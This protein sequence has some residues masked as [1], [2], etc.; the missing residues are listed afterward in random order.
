MAGVEGKVLYE[1]E[2]VVS[3]L[4]LSHVAAQ[5]LDIFIPMLYAGTVY[6]AQPN[7]LRVGTP[8]THLILMF[9]ASYLK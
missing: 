3:Y 6:F 8:L 9:S 1:H 5:V 4:P 2:E 7:A